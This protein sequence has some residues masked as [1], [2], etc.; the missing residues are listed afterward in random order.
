MLNLQKIRDLAKMRKISMN[1]VAE[2]LGMSPQALSKMIR[3]NSTKTST[4]EKLA[5][6]F[7]V[8]IGYFFDGESESVVNINSDRHDVHDS[9]MLIHT[10]GACDESVAHIA[11]LHAKIQN[12]ESLLAEKTKQVDDLQNDKKNLLEILQ[13]LTITK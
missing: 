4:L 5:H 7:N 12:L 2:T 10:E 13:K 9:G 8:P 11:V 1:D 6:L 3:E